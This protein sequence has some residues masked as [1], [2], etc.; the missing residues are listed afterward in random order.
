MNSCREEEGVRTGIE[1]ADPVED[2][3]TA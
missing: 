1:A 2:M 3:W